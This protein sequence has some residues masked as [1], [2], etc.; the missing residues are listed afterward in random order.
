MN[1]E[2]QSTTEELERVN[3]ELRQ[4]G[5][6]LTRLNVFLSAILRSV[7]MG[8]VVLDRDL[9]VELWNGQAAE[10]WGLRQDEVTGRHFF[11]L[12]IGLP[13]EELRQ[14]IQSVLASPD[15]RPQLTLPATNRRGRAIS[16]H[17]LLTSVSGHDQ[18]PTGVLLLMHPI[19]AT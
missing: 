3:E 16:V 8:I 17:V 12:D 15:N 19:A 9:H 11:G 1:E 13:V 4:R 2:L 10:L 18:P 14:A 6:E 7:P 5:G